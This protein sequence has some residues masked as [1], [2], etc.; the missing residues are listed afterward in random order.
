MRI[1]FEGDFGGR[2]QADLLLIG[3]DG[4]KLRLPLEVSA[5][6]RGSATV[7]VD[8]VAEGFLLLRN[9]A[10]EEVPPRRYTYAAEIERGYPF[11]IVS[12]EATPAERGVELRWE[13]ASEQDL[14]GF[15]VLRVREQSGPVVVVNPVWIP[16]LGDRSNPTVYHYLDAAALEGVAYV[17][18]VQGIT[19][20]G[21]TRASDPVGVHPSAP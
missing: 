8:D 11:E 9:V 5:E 21:L 2:W 10:G 14:L 6:G 17:Y 3:R 20:D 15:N 13:T 18:R 4:T 1:Y 16:A 19:R 7:P 12:I